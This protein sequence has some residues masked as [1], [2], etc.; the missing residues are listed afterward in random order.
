MR[1]AASPSRTERRIGIPPPTLASKATSTPARRAAP[2]ISL[3]C[4]ASS[5]LLAVTTGLPAASARR[6]SRRAAS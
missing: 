2:K 1:L 3:P 4:T 5:A 6:V